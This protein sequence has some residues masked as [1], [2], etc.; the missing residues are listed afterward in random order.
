MSDNLG[1][2]DFFDAP[3][4]TRKS[5]VEKGLLLAVSVPLIARF[6]EGNAFGASENVRMERVGSTQFVYV[7]GTDAVTLD[8]HASPDVGYSFNLCRGPAEALV[9]YGVTKHGVVA[10]PRLATSW[11]HNSNSTVWDSLSGRESSSRTVR[12]LTQQP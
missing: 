9:Q 10:L 4:I 2:L 5:L 11:K 12:A 3:P 6:T 1:G 8:P 7:D